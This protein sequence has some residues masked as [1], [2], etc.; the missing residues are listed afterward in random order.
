MYEANGVRRLSGY[1][2]FLV[3]AIRDTSTRY[4]EDA[5]NVASLGALFD[6][7]R[8]LPGQPDVWYGFSRYDNPRD[9][10]SRPAFIDGH[11]TEFWSHCFSVRNAL[12]DALGSS[13]N[14]IGLWSDPGAK[15]GVKEG[16][17]LKIYSRWGNPEWGCTDNS[18]DVLT[19]HLC[20]NPY[21]F[22]QEMFLD[23]LNHVHM[24]WRPDVVG[25]IDTNSEASTRS[26]HNDGEWLDK[27]LVGIVDGELF[28]RPELD[29]YFESRE[30]SGEA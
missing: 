4:V 5:N 3:Q 11:R 10:Y 14:F 17:G 1:P 29:E 22:S 25:I 24:L 9:F 16:G 26:E 12:E 18:R 8:Q 30:N 2:A 6:Y 13:C 20:S 15:Y 23:I 19:I 7:Y 27:M 21:L 28:L